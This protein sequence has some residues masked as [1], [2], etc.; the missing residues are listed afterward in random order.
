MG[1]KKAA[2]AAEAAD[3]PV[4]LT[5]ALRVPKHRTK[6]IDMADFDTR[7]TPAWTGDGKQ[8]APAAMAAIEPELS[9]LQ[10]RL[11]AESKVSGAPVQN[12]LVVLQGLDTSGKGGVIR[13]AIGMVDPQGVSL[14]SFKAPTDEE[15]SH[16]FLWRIKRA[17]PGAGMIG[18]FDRSHYE[19]VLVTRVNRWIDKR[20]WESRYDQINEFEADLAAQGTT[21]LKCWLNVSRDEQYA[22]LQER[23]HNPEKHWKYN[24]GDLDTR[25][26]WDDYQVAIAE[27]ISQTNTD[28]APWFV[29][30][31]DRKWYRNWAVAQLLL[32]HL[33]ALDLAWPAADFDVEAELAKLAELA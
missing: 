2:A 33:R 4:D 12:V 20:T 7:A 11:Y 30:P 15:K 22:R 16:H 17:L 6:R 29:I 18:I 21:I 5:S 10:E 13:K 14:A 24:T 25:R 1:K 8:D 3:Q 32:E 9:D 28:V 27:A 19:D 23:L 26:Q 31:A